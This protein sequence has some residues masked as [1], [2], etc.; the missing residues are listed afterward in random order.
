MSRRETMPLYRGPRAAVRTRRGRGAGRGPTMWPLEVVV[1]IHAFRMQLK[2]GCIDEYRRR[3]D[4]I[5][6]ELAALLRD[7]GMR[8]YRIFVDPGTHSLFA[9]LDRPQ[10]TEIE[11]LPAN[12]VMRR[13]WDYMADLMEVDATHRPLEYALEQV[14]YLP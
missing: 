11:R 5:W 1:N 6:P 3:H 13:W 14:F 4:E 12:P 8:E 7:A 2:P 9:I 10:S